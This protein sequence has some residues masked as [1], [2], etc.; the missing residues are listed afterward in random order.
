[1][2]VIKINGKDFEYEKIHLSYET[3]NPVQNRD[4]AQE[5]LLKFRE[6]AD[7]HQIKVYL[8]WGTLLGAVREKDFIKGDYDTDIYVTDEKKLLDIIP[9]LY[10]HNIKLCRMA[11]GMY[12]SFMYRE[13]TFID[14]V[15]KRPYKFCV[16]G[17][18][19]YQL[20]KPLGAVPKKYF[21][22]E[23]AIELF[24]ETFYCPSTPENILRFWYGDNWR[25]PV[26]GHDFHYQ[27]TLSLYTMKVY[28]FFKRIVIFI[29][30]CCR[31]IINNGKNRNE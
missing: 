19:C 21:R 25:I 7:K 2:A 3:I 29:I 5:L 22:K 18:W 15:I 31:K 24:G 10:E 14:V 17:L 12:Y 6:I 28:R 4:I 20:G 23:Q 8:L 27:I 1:M 13:G 11:K 26:S 9:V 16:F 30:K